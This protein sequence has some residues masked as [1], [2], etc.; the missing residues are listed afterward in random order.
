MSLHGVDPRPKV[1][2]LVG[3]PRRR[4]NTV[5]AVGMATQEFERRGVSC[6]TVMLC[7]FTAGLIGV[8][9]DRHQRERAD[10]RVER[11]L[12]RVWAADGLILATPIH[13]CNV[14]AQMKA[15]MDGTNDRFLNKHWLTP[16]TVGLLAIG[17]QGGFTETIAT[18]RRYLDLVAPSHPRIEIA[19]GHA[20]AAGEAQWS[21]EVREAARAMAVRVA[22]N[23]LVP[24]ISAVTARTGD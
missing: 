7:D 12:D 6:E 8:E 4:G 2:A 15:F 24:S 5:T 13:F 10:D 16:K 11:L 14:S 20:D 19:T 1:V 9:A 21:L 17:A 22:D 3:S 18:M 23:L